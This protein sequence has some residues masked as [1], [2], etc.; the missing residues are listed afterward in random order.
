MFPAGFPDGTS[1]TWI[2]VEAAEAV[3]WT[4]PDDLPYDGVMPLPALGGPSGRY[5][6]AY[7]DGRAATYRRGQIDETNMRRLITRDDGNVVN[8][9]D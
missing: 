1:N 4:K 6:V 9:P 5:S 3:P 2:V 7:A 8:I